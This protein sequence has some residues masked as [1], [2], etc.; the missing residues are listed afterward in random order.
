V[1][2]PRPDED[3]ARMVRAQIED[4]GIRTPRVLDAMRS[5]PRDTFVPDHLKNR[6]Y[7]DRPLEIGCGQT[8]SQPYM[9]ALMTQ[10]LDLSPDDRVLEIGTGSGYQAAIL[11]ELADHVYSIERI[12][13]LAASARARLR[14]LGKTNVDVLTGDG[15]RGYPEAAP[16]DAIIVTAA[17]PHL[18][19]A[20]REQL[21]DGG[22][23]IC[24]VGPRDVQKLVKVTRNGN[25]FSEQ[26]SI[27][28]VFVPLIGEHAWSDS[29]T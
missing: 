26:T 5:V 24:P 19:N 2:T 25:N 28:C 16:F 14:E 6:A 12:A 15:T 13:S 20:L 4:R 8:I 29:S 7:D 27:G 22:R 21:A 18:P 11:S 10:L 1:N 3:R 17:A 23:L 9:V